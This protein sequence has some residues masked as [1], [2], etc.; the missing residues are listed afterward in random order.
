MNDRLVSMLLWAGWFLSSTIV[1]ALIK[2]ADSLIATRALLPET[3]Q[4]FAGA[5]IGVIALIVTL[6]ITEAYRGRQPS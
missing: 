6:E 1:A 3:A 2:C 4:N 5:V